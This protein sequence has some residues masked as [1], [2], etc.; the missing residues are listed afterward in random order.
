MLNQLYFVLQLNDKYLEKFLMEEW[1]LQETPR[2]EDWEITKYL[3]I[4]S[5][6]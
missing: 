2:C 4:S 6:V 5:T 3:Y 1:N